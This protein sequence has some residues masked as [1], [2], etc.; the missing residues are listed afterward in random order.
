MEYRHPILAE[1]FTSLEEA[2]K[3]LEDV[4]RRTEIRPVRIRSGPTVGRAVVVVDDDGNILDYGFTKKKEV[5]DLS[6]LLDLAERLT[7]EGFVFRGYRPLYHG[8]AGIAV[9]SPG[10]GEGDLGIDFL[11]VDSLNEKFSFRIVP[12]PVWRPL[13]NFLGTVYPIPD[14]F[15][16]K[17]RSPQTDISTL[18]QTLRDVI[19]SQVPKLEGYK[20]RLDKVP[21]FLDPFLD[22]VLETTRRNSRGKNQRT[23]GKLIGHAHNLVKAV[24]EVFKDKRLRK[25]QG[26]WRLL[27][28][29]IAADLHIL[30]YKPY[31]DTYVYFSILMKREGRAVKAFRQFARRYKIKLTP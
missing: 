6:H 5:H 28:A 24:A 2:R 15:K 18:A 8:L 7:E 9:L 26:T 3:F 12:F 17:R 16:A 30:P 31:S 4:K 25:A 13:H 23:V 1:G 10:D 22:Y 11:L 19:S 14:I 27:Q 29:V 21:G 20:R